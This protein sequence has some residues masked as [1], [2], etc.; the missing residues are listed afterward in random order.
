MDSSER[1]VDINHDRRRFLGV[2]RPTA[3]AVGATQLALT[4]LAKAQTS[5][6]FGPLKQINAGVLNVGYVEL[7]PDSGRPVIL[8]HGFPY[9]IR[10]YVE[11]APLPPAAENDW[12]YQ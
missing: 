5:T 3:L 4:G 12:W 2:A 8:M 11:V 10:S 6:A 7:G 1:P 9:D